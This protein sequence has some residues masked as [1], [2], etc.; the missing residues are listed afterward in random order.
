MKT[1]RDVLIA[2]I[3]E[4]RPIVLILGQNAWAD[5]DNPD[6]ILA[7][8][9]DRVGRTD[10]PETGWPAL[11]G[12]TPLPPSFYDWLAE[13][14]ERRVP[15]AWLAVLN[16]LP[17]SAVF[18]SALDPTLVAMLSGAGREP[19]AILTASEM[20]RAARSKARPPLYYLFGR[21]GSPDPKA[22]P[23]IDRGGLN[24]RRINHA[25]PMFG[26]VLDTA[27]ALGL[28][29][30]DG[31]V[32]G[33]D[34]LKIED[35]LGTIGG[36]T[37]EQ[38]LWFGGRPPLEI[39]DAS[40]FDTAIA[41]RQ[42][43]VEEERL[44]T[45]A[46]ELRALGRLP[47]LVAP[48]SEEAGVVS[49]IDDKRL[50]TTPEE[51]LRV[52]AVASI[53]DD[54]W[55]AFLSPLGPDAVYDAFRRFHGDLG[56][57]RLLVEGVR[58]N[59]AIERDFERALQRHVNAALADHSSVDGP[60]I[61]HG[62]SGTGKSV[63]LAR[64]VARVREMKSAAVLYAL[65]RV[66]QSYEVSSFCEAAEKAGAKSTLIV[67][68]ANREIE[69]YRDLLMSLRSQGRRVVL[70]GSRYRI[71]DNTSGQ[72]RLSIEAPTNLSSNERQT[73]SDLLE[74]FVSEQLDPELFHDVHILAFLYRALPPSRSRL[75]AGLGAEARAAEQVL[76]IRGRQQ[77][78][79]LQDTQLAQE[80]VRA[81]FANGYQPLFDEQQSVALEAEDTSGRI[82]DLVMLAG[83]LN[84]SVPVN[85]LLR[86]VTESI[87]R[88]DISL[89]ADMFGELDLFRW[90]WADAE[91]SELLVLPRITL[92]AELIC[93]RRLGSV[94]KESERL[95]ELIKA[96]RSAG[97]DRDHERRFLLTLLHQIGAD[98]SRGRRYRHAYVDIARTLTE[99][100]RQFGVIHPSLALQESAFRRSAIRVH[101]VEDHERLTLLEEA[102]DAV[103]TALDAISDGSI[104]APKRTVQN[105]QVER[106][107][108]YGYLAY[109]RAKS[110][111]VREIWSSYQAAR[112]AIRQAVSVTDNYFPLD[113]GLWTPADL[114]RMADLSVEHRAELT[115]DIYATLDQVDIDTLPPKQREKFDSR[116]MNVGRLLK[117]QTLAEEAY[118]AL[119]ASG[120]TA[121]YFLRARELAPELD[122]HMVQVTRSDD[123]DR[124]RR[125][126]DFLS[127]RLDKISH[128]ER[129][130]S[131]LLEYRWI[132]EMGLRPL[133]GQRQPLPSERGARRRLLTIVSAVNEASGTA[134][135]HV[136]RYLEAVL[137]WLV[138]DD[139]IARQIFRE[140]G[141]ETE[142]EDPSRVVRRHLITDANLVP[143]FFEGRIERQRSE[144]HW[145]LRVDG[146]NRL[147]DL[148]SRDFPDDEIAY[149]RTIRR[150]GIAFNYIGPIAD[151]IKRRR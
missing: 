113:V 70:L 122:R 91:R 151:P 140:L 107:S 12:T 30:I 68:D 32:P 126:A 63:A 8:A 31:F 26:R 1:A 131:L 66:P 132:A 103:Q 110:G 73:L 2:A 20:P 65:G 137:T 61:V 19:E 45:V 29:V 135:R 108:L 125:A 60:L 102:R 16:E 56:G 62:Q 76:R 97:I 138:G 148:L 46:A 24:V 136:T 92:E 79:L 99:L 120:S 23:P 4:Q 69:H 78:P 5:S 94:E 104:S 37:P 17:W 90:K 77:R 15:P 54:S 14:F 114:L 115:A 93:R 55:T 38:I 42:I 81:G 59:F 133:R 74:H 106:A 128:D 53:V 129:C 89:V 144:G 101:V 3:Q 43:L 64:I 147:V 117:N 112:S 51:R 28:V 44:G 124:A 139:Q 58:R 80:L 96:V 111:S 121:G 41:S 21:A 141:Q 18:T 33:R 86:A 105:L 143:T 123:L 127:A 82:I 85:L 52:E 7:K 87:P 27:T 95:I 71:T 22:H 11:L 10:V 134:S 50:E 150:F 119:E 146:L 57:S 25:F 34:W 98:G 84:C 13:R 40:D 36:A 47:D 6:A 100:R 35:V 49:F 9:L 142:Y 67:C 145:N 75:G 83:S 130:L 72:S 118:A 149:G 39:E 116:R 109:D 48:E 88:S